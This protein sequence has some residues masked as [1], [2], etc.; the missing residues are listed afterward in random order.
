MGTAVGPPH[1]LFLR[2]RSGCRYD[3]GDVEHIIVSDLQT[4]I[5][6]NSSPEP[7][8]KDLV[9]K[10]EAADHAMIFLLE[11]VAEIGLSRST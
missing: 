8:T 7:I 6:D 1:L 3:S 5:V 9:T 4:E 11:L 2:T 10:H